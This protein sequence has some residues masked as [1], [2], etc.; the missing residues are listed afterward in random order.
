MLSR[1]QRTIRERSLFQRGDRVLCAV[2]GGPDSMALMHVLWELRDRLGLTLEVATVDHGLR[3]EA[4]AEAELVAGRAR[5]LE[6]PWHLLP[7]DVRAARAATRSSWQDA[8]RRV[9]LATLAEL[10]AALGATKIAL[11]HQADDQVETV[12]FRI[13]RGTGVKGLSGIPYRRGPFVRPLLDLERAPILGYLRRRAIPFVED[14]SNRDPRF[15]RARLRHQI[16]PSLRAENPRLGEALRALAADA[17]RAPRGTPPAGLPVLNRRAVQ[18]IERLRRERGGTRSIDVAGGRVQISYGEVTW[19]PSPSPS[20]SPSASASAIPIPIPVTAP[21]DYG[22]SGGTRIAIR[23]GAPVAGA[24]SFDA[25]LVAPPLRL[26]SIRA[27]DRM[28]P[29]GGRGARKL[30]DLLIDAKIAR[31]LRRLLPVLTT[32][33]DQILFVPGLRPAELGRPRAATSRWLSVFCPPSRAESNRGDP[34]T[35]V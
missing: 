26:R 19:L 1:V 3:P 2:S 18:A 34:E 4:R 8:A 33:D 23:E 28:R 17:A 16:I 15:A 14:P 25:D 20:P 5:D 7:V 35:S 6:L 12:L 10:A 29:R 31:P 21:G 30:S 9:R 32:V 13:L 22:W 27:G 24:A 11:G